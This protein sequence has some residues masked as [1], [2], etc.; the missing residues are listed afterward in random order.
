DVEC[1][2]LG[3]ALERR[4]LVRLSNATTPHEQLGVFDFPARVNEA[5]Q[6]LGHFTTV[7]FKPNPFSEL[8]LFRGCYLTSS[9]GTALDTSG[10]GTERRLTDKGFFATDL[11]REVLLP[12]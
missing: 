12:D 11:F 7:L 10:A 6:K 4:R 3:D 2:Y 8:P 5:R 9:A 1:N